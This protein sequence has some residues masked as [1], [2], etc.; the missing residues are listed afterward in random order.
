MILSQYDPI[1][2]LED[3]QPAVNVPICFY[4]GQ[5]VFYD[6]GVPVRATGTASV[7]W[8]PS[9][10]IEVE[11]E[12]DPKTDEEMEV[13]TKIELENIDVELQGYEKQNTVPLSR[14]LLPTHK[15]LATVTSIESVDKRQLEV[16]RF[17]VVNGPEFL[18]PGLRAHVGRP[19]ELF[20]KE[21]QLPPR[22]TTVTFETA[23]LFYEDWQI[24]LVATDK[25]K[26]IRKR[27]ANSNGYGFTHQGQIINPAGSRFSSQEADK[28]LGLLSKF[29]SFLRGASCNLPILQG[30][31]KDG[32]ISWQRFSS[33]IVDSGKKPLTWFEA[34]HGGILPGLFE[35]FCRQCKGPNERS[36]QVALHW[37]QECNKRSGG[38]ETA[39][40]LGLTALEL[41]SSL[42][43]VEQKKVLSA[44][45]HKDLGAAEKLA[46]LLEEMN[47]QSH[48][49]T[50]FSALDAF[51]QAQ[52]WSQSYEA[53]TKIRNGFVHSKNIARNMIFQA[54]PGVLF[55]AWQLSLW[56][57][58]LS[59]LYLLDY[60]GKYRNRTTAE[61]ASEVESVPWS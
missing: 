25:S 34:S 60:Q 41:L 49:P 27:V 20:S 9:P 39:I 50:R 6:S 48:I 11:A 44:T 42:V 12:L 51:V 58:E 18:T 56:Y 30:V 23:R 21:D 24:N 14:T 22:N 38:I 3:E 28:I 37:Y 47:T 59:L 2:S 19:A 10:R 13:A 33:A 29:L 32:Q 57:Q 16:I 53:L 40:I 52:G 43:L 55:Q 45:S 4:E 15:I 8:L 36:F 54:P 7:V 26:E 31:E 61:W 46:C 35:K 5:M 1:S 17:P